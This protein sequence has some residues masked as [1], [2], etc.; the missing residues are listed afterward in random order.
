MAS[1]NE[2]KNDLSQ[3]ANALDN[4]V[5]DSAYWNAA[6][7]EVSNVL[8]ATG[9]LLPASNPNFR[10]LWTAGTPRIKEAMVEYLA[11]DWITG[12]PREPVLNRMFEVGLCTDDEIY[13]DREARFEMPIYRD[14]L[15]PWDFGNVCML[16]LL[17]PEGY[18]PMTIH[19]ANDHPPLT[20][21]DLSLIEE[22]RAKFEA[23]I[24]KASAFALNRFFEF[25][26]FLTG[27]NSELFLFDADGNHCFSIDEN[28]S[29]S[30]KENLA[31]LLPPSLTQALQDDLKDILLSSPERSLSKAYQFT[32][33][34][35]EVSVLVVQIPKDLRHF[36]MAFKTCA[37][38][39]ESSAADSLKHARL[40]DQYALSDTEILTVSQLAAGKTPAMIAEIVGLKPSSIR[41]RLKTI[42]EKTDVGGQI[43]LAALYRSI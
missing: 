40:R 14:F 31:S 41:Q 29:A 11:K 34:G 5:T 25:A 30:A 8:G 15:A 28:G 2:M 37:V 24:E 23:A 32:K 26:T 16:R 35:K 33:D 19:F 9:T 1:N 4:A 20:Q 42:F 43:E 17:T 18:W 10:G 6:C 39:T 38:R 27:S 36:F 12:D 21:A 7:E 22:I 3:L 13:P